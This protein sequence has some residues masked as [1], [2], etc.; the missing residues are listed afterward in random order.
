MESQDGLREK[1]IYRVTLAGSVINVLL[2]VGKFVAGILGHSAAMM[3]D[4]VHS[5]TDFV[6]DIIVLVFVKLGSKPKD[7][8]HEYGHGKYETLA[9]V[10]IGFS[11]F[12]VGIM[13]CFDGLKKIYQA[14]CG[15][16]LAQPG[17]IALAAAVV[18]ILLK[19]W[20]FRFTRKVGR[21]V[22]SEAVVANAW[23]HRSDAL[24]SVGTF[25]GIGGAIL[26]GRQ[27]AVLDPIA[28]LV[29]S[30][31]IIKASIE[32]IKP[33]MDELMEKSLP[34]EVEDEIRSIAESVE[35]VSEVHH[36][37]TRSIGGH[38]AME[39]HVR[40]RGNMTLYESHVHATEIECKLRT[41]FGEGTHIGLHV[42]PLKVNGRYER[43]SD[44]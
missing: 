41:R 21:E 39:M 25:F 29:V 7:A 35:G 4:A 14:L 22:G 43:P 1:H 19:E 44:A 26:L 23:H 18:S 12:L 34:R 31:L 40:M 15:E 11:L 36:L 20:A 16:E 38:I 28:A 9:S 10:I 37:M 17:M 13:I 3:A 2:L 5:L 8:D 30:V 27:W 33:S 24:S 42:E 6:T 32:L